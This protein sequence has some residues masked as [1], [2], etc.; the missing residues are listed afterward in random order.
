MLGCDS[1]RNVISFSLRWL[2]G[3]EGKSKFSWIQSTLQQGTRCSLVNGNCVR[4]MRW[5]R[6]C[7]EMFLC[8]SHTLLPSLGNGSYTSNSQRNSPTE[9]PDW[10]KQVSDISA[11]Q[12][13]T[14]ALPHS[15]LHRVVH[16]AL[17]YS[18]TIWWQFQLR[19]ANLLYQWIGLDW[20]T[21]C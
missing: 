20:P 17:L 11:A 9:G 7:Q 1:L 4:T 2:D 12:V 13:T 6:S 15:S 8:L 21:S 18:F 14:I 19:S 16:S 3:I 5:R 10:P